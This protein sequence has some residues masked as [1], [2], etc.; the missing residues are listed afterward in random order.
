MIQRYHLISLFSVLCDKMKL[1]EDFED[2]DVTSF[3]EEAKRWILSTKN[4]DAFI[5]TTIN[6]E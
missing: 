4:I 5:T 2:A 6:L 3:L 1:E